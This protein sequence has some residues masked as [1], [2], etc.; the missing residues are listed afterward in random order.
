MK[1]KIAF[2]VNHFPSVSE[3]FILNQITD[4]MSRGYTVEVYAFNRGTSKAVHK[5]ILEFGLLDKTTYFDKPPEA[6]IAKV[7]WT[8]FFLIRHFKT[9]LWEPRSE[10]FDLRKLLRRIRKHS[11]YVSIDR[12]LQRGNFDI[13]H[14]HF[15]QRG[16]AIAHAINKS[17]KKFKFIT[18]F[19]GY[20][21]NPSLLPYYKEA[22]KD[23]FRFADA[24][25]VNSPYLRDL[26]LRV[27]DCPKNLSVLCEGLRTS[28][29]RK[30]SQNTPA[31]F[32]GEFTIIFCGRFVEFKA[33]DLAVE[34]ISIL[35]RQ[36][37]MKNVKLK[38][39]GDGPMRKHV[40]E[41]IVRYNLENNV[42]LLGSRTQEQVVEEMNSADV[43]LLP[44]VHEVETGRAEAQGLVIQEAQAIE[45]PV[46]VS[47]A[48]GIRYGV[49]DGKTGFVVAQRNL[50]GF[51]DKLE[52][53]GTD[54]Q[55]RKEMGT[56]GREYVVSNFD[57]TILGDQLIE[58]Y[59]R[60]F[61]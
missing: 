52:L 56:R 42:I 32:R 27:N 54:E 3:T 31:V 33:P 28:Q 8:V 17:G 12:F 46:V 49:I 51:A 4:V 57:T 1:Y 26:L 23:I 60:M 14:A 45:L 5:S 40:E 10:M 21:L 37:G 20:D 50:Q 19:H 18:S 48:G 61:L 34:I 9:L 59:D 29:Y 47:D 7:G 44:G 58:I 43:F 16:A 13:V 36:R 24:L 2:I 39:I 15:G 30:I 11:E 41:M 55:L 22:Y 38:M 35:V 6:L 53:L 25:T